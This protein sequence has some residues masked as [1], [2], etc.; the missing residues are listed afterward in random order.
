MVGFNL[1]NTATK[2]SKVDVFCL[3]DLDLHLIVPF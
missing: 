2:N 1:F 3:P